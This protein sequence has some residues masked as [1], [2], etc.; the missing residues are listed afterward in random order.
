MANAVAVVDDDVYLRE[1]P[2]VGLLELV[3]ARVSGKETDF[4]LNV[5]WTFSFETGT[6]WGRGSDRMYTALQMSRGA[7]W[8][9]MLLSFSHPSS[10]HQIKHTHIK[11][12]KRLSSLPRPSHP[13]ER[14]PH[15]G[16]SWAIDVCVYPVRYMW[17]ENYYYYFYYKHLSYPRFLYLTGIQRPG[18]FTLDCLYLPS[19]KRTVTHLHK[20][21]DIGN[22]T[23]LPNCEVRKWSWGERFLFTFLKKK[24]T[25]S[26]TGGSSKTFCDHLSHSHRDGCK[27]WRIWGRRGERDREERCGG[28]AHQNRER[29]LI[30]PPTVKLDRQVNELELSLEVCQTWHPAY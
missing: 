7:V 16:H 13:D 8:T 27:R 14:C 20:K 23:D 30:M 25:S 2:L 28:L 4:D 26:C 18:L 3:F 19:L 12:I 1:L 10:I 29:F 24:C 15:S 11:E 6:V 9:Q 17:T 21:N 5:C 22:L